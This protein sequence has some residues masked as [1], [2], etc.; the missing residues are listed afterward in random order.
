MND[1]P[2]T[3][4]DALRVLA[5]DGFDTSF[6]LIDGSVHDEA[7]G[8]THPIERVTALRVYRFEGPSDPDEE[9]AVFAVRCP[10]CGTRGT[11]VTSYGPGADPALT[12]RLD[13]PGA[14]ARDR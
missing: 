13:V 9:A 2:A 3:V 1:E 5:A 12:D 8:T 4:L 11:F 10:H 14:H 7:C 6:A